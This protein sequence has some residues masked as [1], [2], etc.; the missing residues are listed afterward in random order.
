MKSKTKT[1]VIAVYI[2]IAVNYGIYLLDIF[3]PLSFLYLNHQNAYIYQFLTSAF[4]HGSFAHL[5]GNMFFI[6]FFGKLIEEE[7]GDSVLTLI[8]ISSAIIVNVSSYILTSTTGYSLGASGVVFAFFSFT[9]VKRVVQ[10]S[11]WRSWIEIL[12]LG[13]FVL[14]YLFTEFSMVD[15]KDNIGHSAHLLGGICGAILFFVLRRFSNA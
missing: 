14:S 1:N 12:V 13:P 11:D 7:F 5:T 2:F 15:V 8:Y 9:L 3:L 6:F 10:K 4:C